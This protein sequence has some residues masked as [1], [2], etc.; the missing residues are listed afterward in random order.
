MFMLEPITGTGDISAYITH[1]E[2]LSNLMNW[3]AS[4]KDAD[5]K[6]Q[7]DCDVNLLYIERRHQIFPLKI[8]TAI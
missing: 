4:R 1:F 6:P 8:R 2:I 7:L 5:G 3:L